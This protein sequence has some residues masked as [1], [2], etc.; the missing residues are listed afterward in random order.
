MRIG[1]PLEHA[2]AAIKALDVVDPV[3]RITALGRQI[4]YFGYLCG[5]MLNWVNLQ[6]IPCREGNADGTIRRTPPR[7]DLSPRP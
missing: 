7:S 4:G 2:Q 1:K 5:D 3:L 6:S